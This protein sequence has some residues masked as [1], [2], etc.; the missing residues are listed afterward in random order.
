MRFKLCLVPV[1]IAGLAQAQDDDGLAARR[2]YY[3]DN[4]PDAVFKATTVAKKPLETSSVVK[5][6]T[7]AKSP[8][9]KPAPVLMANVNKAQEIEKIQKALR[10]AATTALT[11]QAS[12]GVPVLKPAA[13]LGVRYNILKVELDDK[14]A[15]KSRTEIA[16]DTV[17]HEHDCLAVRIQ[18]NRGGFLYV[19]AEGTSGDFRPLIPSMEMSD[20][21]NIVTAYNLME[22]P[23]KS[24]F[25][26][27]DQPG[28]EKLL[29]VVT[30]KPEDVMKLN[31]IMKK[32]SKGNLDIAKTDMKPFTEALQS[33]DLKITHYNH[34][35]VP[36]ESPYT[37]YLTNA[38]ATTA[39]RLVLEIK[40]KHEK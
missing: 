22:V 32:K 3:Q 19:F 31:D 1:M 25:E 39:D 10:E 26:M 12:S 15:P 11:S 18:P 20:E 4:A 17:F 33:R 38:A 30:D 13:N 5:A 7:V 36:G 40:L 8:A 37:T 27:D 16:P 24:C 34:K 35:V 9:P 2:L 14:G 23:Q 6:T 28:V 21:S 29:F